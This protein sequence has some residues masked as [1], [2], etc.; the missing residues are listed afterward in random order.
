MELY[1]T[2]A[3]QRISNCNN[4][5]S[6]IGEVQRLPTL[7]DIL[8]TRIAKKIPLKLARSSMSDVVVTGVQQLI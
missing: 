3:P 2:E 4:R 1:R 8:A 7:A 5:I 6:G